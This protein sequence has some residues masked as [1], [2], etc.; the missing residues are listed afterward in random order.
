MNTDDGRPPIL[1]TW[2]AM[3]VV[4]LGTL[5]GLCGLFSLISWIYR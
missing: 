3:Y 2:N 4:V 5:V 1:G